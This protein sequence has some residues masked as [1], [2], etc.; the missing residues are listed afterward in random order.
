MIKQMDWKNAKRIAK[1]MTNAQLGAA[2][3]DARKTAELWDRQ[4]HDPDQ[5]SG[6]YRDQATVYAKEQKHR[7]LDMR[8]LPA[9]LTLEESTK[10]WANFKR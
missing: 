7:G 3:I 5:N 10:F 8:Q 9:P 6:Y 1:G 2:R 4:E